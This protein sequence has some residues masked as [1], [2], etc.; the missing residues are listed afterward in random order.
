MKEKI[1]GVVICDV[2]RKDEVRE[3]PV[4]IFPEKFLKLDRF[5]RDMKGNIDLFEEV[6][7]RSFNPK[8]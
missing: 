3:E 7:I 5:F 4:G 6:K 8:L 1:V 2:E